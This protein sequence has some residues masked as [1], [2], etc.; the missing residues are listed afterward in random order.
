M[1]KPPSR[2]LLNLLGP[3]LG[4]QGPFLCFVLFVFLVNMS[5]HSA[6]IQL[7]ENISITDMCVMIPFLLIWSPHLKGL[8]LGTLYT[9]QEQLSHP[10]CAM[11]ISDAFVLHASLTELRRLQFSHF[12]LTPLFVSMS[13]PS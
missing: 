7:F 5:I 10:P 9:V 8:I 4:F 12:T 3:Y 11:S 6:C 2:D 1:Q 13:H